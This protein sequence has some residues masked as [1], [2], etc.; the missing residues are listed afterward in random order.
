MADK[1]K[2]VAKIN[3]KEYTLTSTESRE[4]MLSVAD[5]V[6]RKMKQAMTADPTMSTAYTAVLAAI[7]LADDYLRL[8]KAEQAITKNMLVYTEKIKEL[9][10]QIEKLKKLC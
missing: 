4:Y 10:E 8:K 7:N 3:G 6:D 9:E 2:L 1:N 5:L